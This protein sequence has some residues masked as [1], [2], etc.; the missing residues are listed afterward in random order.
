M[1]T[2]PT[3]L[4]FCKRINRV[5][6][7]AGLVALATAAHANPSTAW[8]WDGSVPQRVVS[9]S[10][11][12]MIVRPLAAVR[13]GI[14]AALLVPASILASPACAVNLVNGADCRPVFEAPY[15]VLVAEPVDYAFKREIGEL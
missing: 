1:R 7:L 5:M 6:G 13:A 12:V 11:D 3:R 9:S 4:G 8:T 14:G 10:V 15:E 2:R